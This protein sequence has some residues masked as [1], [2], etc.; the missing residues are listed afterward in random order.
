M[1]SLS[2]R[3]Q[4]PVHSPVTV[5]GILAGAGMLASG[6]A[7]ARMRLTD[8]LRSRYQ[9]ADVLL[10]D[11][12]TSAL[13]LALRLSVP[14]GGTVAMPAYSCVDLAAAALRAGVRVRLYDLDPATLSPDV[15]DLERTVKRGVDAILVA[16]L[17]GFPANV[18]EAR[19]ICESVG[20]PLIEDAA[21]GAR[22][23]LDGKP[24]GAFGDLSVLSFGR[25]KGLNG[26]GGGA[27]LGSEPWRRLL[28]VGADSLGSGSRGVRN[29]ATI[30]AQYLLG[31]PWFYWLPS[32]LPWLR[33]GE[34]VYHP[35]NE[36]RAL[37]RAAAALVLDALRTSEQELAYRRARAKRLQGIIGQSRSLSVIQP[38]HGADPGYLRLP[39]L[40]RSGR[41]PAPGCGYPARLPR[42]AR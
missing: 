42:Y 30:G 1:H 28:S 32:S 3:R 6:G 8:T 4:L 24:V 21:Q 23:T 18:R 29:L 5:R 38:V 27:L 25:G 19:R 7:E 35:A 15:D 9:A 17:Y 22:A 11:S 26:G 33:L 40:D 12:G 13:V 36:P 34:M 39:V 37:A 14:A 20:L 10:T 41:A 2:I 31:R 16:H